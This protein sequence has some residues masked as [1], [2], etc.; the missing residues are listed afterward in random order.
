M[1]LLFFCS[2]VIHLQFLFFSHIFCSW[3]VVNLLSDIM[4]ERAQIAQI[5]Q[6]ASTENYVLGKGLPIPS[7]KARKYNKYTFYIPTFKCTVN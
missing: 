5:A 3:D 2:S 4:R 1:F 6:I 7:P